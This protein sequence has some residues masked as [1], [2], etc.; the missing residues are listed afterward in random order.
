[1][2]T[3][4]S[5]TSSRLA[6]AEQAAK[7]DV[8]D[9]DGIRARLTYIRTALRLREAAYGGVIEVTLQHA[10][11]CLLPFGTIPAEGVRAAIKASCEVEI[12]K[13]IEELRGMGVEF[14]ARE[15][16]G[17]AINNRDAAPSN[18]RE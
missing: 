3:A 2:T 13:W 8:Y 14:A 6:G 18:G 11:D 5:G 1:M 15:V 16:T 7:L 9:F 17:T 10:G 4:A 12:A